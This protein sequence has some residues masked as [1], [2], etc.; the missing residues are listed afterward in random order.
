MFLLFLVVVLFALSRLFTAIWLEIWLDKGDGLESER[1][2]NQSIHGHGLNLT[3]TE[4]KGYVTDNP[5]LW[6]VPTRC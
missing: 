3:E 4:L 5:D 1:R 6:Y 2:H